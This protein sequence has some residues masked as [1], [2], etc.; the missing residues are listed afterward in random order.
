MFQKE[1]NLR[2]FKRPLI[3]FRFSTLFK[4]SFLF[5]IIILGL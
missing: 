5:F 2:V 3:V 4:K 1:V